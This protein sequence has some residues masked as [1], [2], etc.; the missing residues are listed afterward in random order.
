[1]ETH[2]QDCSLCRKNDVCKFKAGKQEAESK[3]ETE[4]A[5]EENYAFLSVSLLCS[6]FDV[7]P[8]SNIR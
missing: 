5:A 6:Y 3:I 1:M 4:I 2:V 8:V 7:K